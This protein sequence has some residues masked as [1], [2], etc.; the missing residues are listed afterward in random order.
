MPRFLGKFKS[1]D[2]MAESYAKK[3]GAAAG[4][5]KAQQTKLQ[6]KYQARCEGAPSFEDW[7]I[8]YKDGILKFIEEGVETEK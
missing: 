7:K 5:T 1:C 4:L 2:L 3:V 8:R 6:K